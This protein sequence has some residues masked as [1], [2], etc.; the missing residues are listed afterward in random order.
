MH[1]KKR[2]F[3]S[4]SYTLKVFLREKRVINRRRHLHYSSELENFQRALYPHRKVP[5]AFVFRFTDW[6]VFIELVFQGIYA[7]G[8][9]SPA[10][11]ACKPYR[12]FL[13]N[14]RQPEV[15]LFLFI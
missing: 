15:S 7:E 6:S 10:A 14:R 5:E 12:K 1:N 11:L 3:Y 9:A 8:R 4:R 2:R 13:S